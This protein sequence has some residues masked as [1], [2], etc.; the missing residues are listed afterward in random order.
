MI[1]LFIS[2]LGIIVFFVSDNRPSLFNRLFILLREI[3]IKLSEVLDCGGLSLCG[4]FSVWTRI[5][6]IGVLFGRGCRK[7]GRGRNRKDGSLCG[8]GNLMIF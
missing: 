1:Y 6:I 7:W 8:R 5:S 2:M 4:G 3:L